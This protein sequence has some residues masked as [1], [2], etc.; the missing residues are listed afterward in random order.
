MNQL[1]EKCTEYRKPLCLAFVDNEKVC[2]SVESKAILTS[3]EKRG[4][5]E[6]YIDAL[7]EIQNVASTVA[8]LHTESNKIPI[9]KGARQGGTISPK[10]FTVTLEDLFCNLD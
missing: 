9:R 2:D 5:D 10:L 1:K 8:M 4:I 6:G 3:L 7:A